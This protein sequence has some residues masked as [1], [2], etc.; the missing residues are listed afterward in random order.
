M[1]AISKFLKLFRRSHSADEL[2]RFT[3]YER[4]FTVHSYKSRGGYDLISMRTRSVKVERFRASQFWRPATRQKMQLSLSISLLRL[5][6]L[7][8]EVVAA[9]SLKLNDAAGWV[10]WPKL[11]V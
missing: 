9:P 1:S 6:R 4:K 10:L 11:L 7:G 3:P 2:N 8:I 5:R